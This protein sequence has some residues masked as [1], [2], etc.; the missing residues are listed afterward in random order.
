MAKVTYINLKNSKGEVETIDE[1]RRDEAG[2]VSEYR[3]NIETMLNETSNAYR[4]TNYL[5][6]GSN[7]CTNDWKNR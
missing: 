3:K 5:I 2:S 1:V 6:Y 7:K 4:H